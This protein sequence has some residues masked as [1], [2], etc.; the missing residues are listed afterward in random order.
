ML[1]QTCVRCAETSQGP[2]GPNIA[3]NSCRWSRAAPVGVEL[4]MDEFDNWRLLLAQQHRVVTRAQLLARGF[5]DDGIRAQVEAG[6]WRR[7]HEGVY[8]LHSGPLTRAAQM[9]AALL[10]CGGAALLSHE[11]AGE[12]HGFLEQEA[13]AAI[14]VTVRYGCSTARADGVRVHRSRAFAHIAARGEEP[15]RTSRVHTV[16]DLVNSAPDRHEAARRAHQLALDA[17]VHPLDLERAVELRRPPRFLQPI[18]DAIRL[19]R[20]GVLSALEH[21]YLVDVEK[22]HG[23]PEGRRQGPVL[24]DGVQRYEDI[25]YDLPDGAAVVRLDGFGYHRDRLTALIDRRR[26]VAAAV[27]A[28]PAIPFGWD[29]V[30]RFPCRTAREVEAVVRWLGWA[31]PLL[32]CPRCRE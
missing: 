19:L 6:R 16:L 11:T 10:A 30:T 26:S 5:T 31:D 27:A 3:H 7:V 4:G 9:T 2:I 17:G 13:S 25:T 18:K 20:E 32:S 24:V 22:A 28:T 12:L 1:R 29:E 14:H 21:Q 15:P 8:A 23:L